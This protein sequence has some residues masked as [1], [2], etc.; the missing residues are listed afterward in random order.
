MIR[1]RIPEGVTIIWQKKYDTLI[2]VIRLKVDWAIAIKVAHDK[3]LF[4]IL[5]V[6]TPYKCLQNE[7]EYLNRLAFMRSFI[8]EIECACIFI[9]GDM[10]ADISDDNSLFGQ[11]LI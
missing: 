3:N 7:N 6:Y 4:L 11:H 5:N 9:M 10:N 2:G 1:G 8:K